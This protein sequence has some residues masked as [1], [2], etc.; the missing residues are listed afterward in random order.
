M[1]EAMTGPRPDY[2]SCIP[3]NERGNLTTA[4]CGRDEQPFF[5]S[6][7]HAV[8]N[9]N[10]DGRIIACPECVARVVETLCRPGLEVPEREPV[11][12]RGEADELRAAIEEALEDVG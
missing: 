11:T 1:A 5:V 9:A 4:L 12:S 2:I 3:R 7:D 6:V 8:H 10:S